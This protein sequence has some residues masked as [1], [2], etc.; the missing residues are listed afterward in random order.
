MYEFGID[1]STDPVPVLCQRTASFSLR[2]VQHAEWPSIGP[3]CL[4]TLPSRSRARCHM[5]IPNMSTGG[6][7]HQPNM[8]IRATVLALFLLPQGSPLHSLNHPRVCP[9]ISKPQVARLVPRVYILLLPAL[10]LTRRDD[11]MHPDRQVD[12][13]TVHRMWFT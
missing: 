5:Y 12:Y 7:L 4:R 1:M 9:I 3:P 11:Y 13:S 10:R 6:S 8:R 2:W